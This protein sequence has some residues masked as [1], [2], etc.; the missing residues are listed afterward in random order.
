MQA[1]APAARPEQPAAS[2]H[3]VAEDRNGS[4]A[5]PRRRV[6]RPVR[7]QGTAA[8][9]V[10]EAP[11]AAG[12]AAPVTQ[13]AGVDA[14]SHAAALTG[15][16]A[17]SGS[18][19]APSRS[20]AVG[21]S[22]ARQPA[23][24]DAGAAGAAA[25]AAQPHRVTDVH[26]SLLLNAGLLAR[27]AS[28]R[29]LYLFGVPNTGPLVRACFHRAALPPCTAAVCGIVH[30]CA[31]CTAC[32]LVAQLCTVIE[33]LLWTCSVCEHSSTLAPIASL[34]GYVIGHPVDGVWMCR[35]CR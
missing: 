6:L 32:C 11:P 9:A 22:A 28:D 15:H 31:C 19:A 13:D 10:T 21:E 12:T 29:G 1:A 17:A 4:A 2:T 30:S 33:H 23:H 27:H 18:A 34:S 5:P 3:I 24:S 26:V 20:T 35:P 7:R 8:T 16:A 14:A 25:V